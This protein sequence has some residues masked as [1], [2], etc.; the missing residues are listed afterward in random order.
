MFSS[1]IQ[2]GGG[3]GGGNE[4]ILSSIVD[5]ENKA[6]SKIKL[7]TITVYLHLRFISRV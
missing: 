3:R 1:E 7:I 5:L 2:L 4:G 6:Q